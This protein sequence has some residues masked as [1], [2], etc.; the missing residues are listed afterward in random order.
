MPSAILKK[1]LGATMPTRGWNRRTFLA[2]IAPA[3]CLSAAAGSVHKLRGRLAPA[4]E[5]PSPDGDSLVFVTL[6]GQKY[7]V[8]G[9]IYSLGQLRDP[10]LEGRIWELEG[11]PGPHA[12]FEIQRLFTIKDDKRYVVTYYCD[13]CNIYTHEPGKC[14]CCQKETELQEHLEK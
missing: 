14:M 7:T 4:V 1:G 6:D 9:D 3:A 13:V 8:S 5:Q 2:L 10:R 11:I 12:S